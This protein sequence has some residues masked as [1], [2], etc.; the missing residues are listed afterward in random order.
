[1]NV[2]HILTKLQTNNFSTICNIPLARDRTSVDAVCASHVA[3]GRFKMINAVGQQQQQ[4][5]S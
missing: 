1:M 2:L 5:M 3:I 4:L